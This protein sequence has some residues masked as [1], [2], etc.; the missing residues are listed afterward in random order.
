MADLTSLLADGREAYARL[1]WPEARALLSAARSL[2]ARSYPASVFCGFDPRADAIGAARK[3]A[4]RA[5]VSD[6]VTFEVARA[7]EFP[8]SEY[9]LIFVQPGS[10]GGRRLRGSRF[11]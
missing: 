10:P 2:L 11:S 5:A 3:V 4:A 6:R 9:D 7:D 8:G 1:D